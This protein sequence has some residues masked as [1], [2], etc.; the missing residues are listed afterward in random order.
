MTTKNVMTAV[1]VAVFLYSV[2]AGITTG[3]TIETSKPTFT[4]D[5]ERNEFLKDGQV[6]RYVSGSLHYFR[7][8]KPYWKDRIQKMKAAGLNAIS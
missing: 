7:V 3:N 1:Y 4:V 5:Y 8:P 2:V 6:F